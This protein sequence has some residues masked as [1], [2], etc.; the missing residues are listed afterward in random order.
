MRF[1]GAKATIRG[2]HHI[3]VRTFL[4]K[5]KTVHDHRTPLQDLAA[6]PT[7]CS[8]QPLPF[9]LQLM[10][11]LAVLLVALMGHLT[12]LRDLSPEASQMSLLTCTDMV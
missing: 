8:C 7:H 11:P 3:M 1:Q 10:L 5:T 6:A 4:I 9:L 12:F 2:R